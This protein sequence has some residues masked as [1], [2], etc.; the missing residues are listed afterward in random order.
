MGEGYLAVMALKAG[1]KSKK[2]THLLFNMVTAELK[3][4]TLI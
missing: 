4:V 2:H 1:F 3:N